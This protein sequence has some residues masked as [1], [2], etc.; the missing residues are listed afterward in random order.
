MR[1]FCGQQARKAAEACGWQQETEKLI[2]DY[3]R[4]IVI[5]GQRGLLGRLQLALVR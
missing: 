1:R 5:N 3:R 2:D 4:A